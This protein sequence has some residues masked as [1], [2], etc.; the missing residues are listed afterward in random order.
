[1]SMWHR[2]AVP[3][4]MHTDLHT[5]MIGYN[6]KLSICW[7]SAMWT[8]DYCHRTEVQN[9]IFSSTPLVFLSRI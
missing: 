3:K 4:D 9:S 7:D 1:M 2:H 6:K 8:V 5:A